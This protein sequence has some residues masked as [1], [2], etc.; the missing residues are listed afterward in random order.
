M[1]YPFFLRKSTVYANF[2]YKKYGNVTKSTQSFTA[3]DY[4]QKCPTTNS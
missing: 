4:C 3:N 2:Q 1:P